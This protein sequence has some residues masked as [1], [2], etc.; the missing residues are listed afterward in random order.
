MQIIIYNNKKAETYSNWLNGEEAKQYINPSSDYRVTSENLASWQSTLKNYDK[1]SIQ[2]TVQFNA[3]QV[4]NM[5]GGFCMYIK[6]W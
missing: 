6:Q 5:S 2:V 1:R 4:Q 3:I